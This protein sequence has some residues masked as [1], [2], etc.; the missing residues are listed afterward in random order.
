MQ[1]LSLNEALP[2][3]RGFDEVVLFACQRQ[4]SSELDKIATLGVVHFLGLAPFTVKDNLSIE[5]NALAHPDGIK[6]LCVGQL[7]S[8]VTVPNLGLL[9][10]SNNTS[11]I[12]FE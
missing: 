11:S 3:P 7:Q 2:V 5:Q 10:E 4:N 9:I 6:R 8:P 12:Q 1:P